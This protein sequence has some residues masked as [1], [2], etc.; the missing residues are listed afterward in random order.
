MS[1][2]NDRKGAVSARVLTCRVEAGERRG[3]MMVFVAV[4][5]A[6]FLAMVAISIEIAHIQLARTELRSAT[7]AASKAAALEL[8]RTQVYS[9]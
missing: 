4:L 9:A 8:A 6:G 1:T 7:D 2:Q 5:L 3:A